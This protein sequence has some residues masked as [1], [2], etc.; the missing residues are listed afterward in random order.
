MK[1]LQEI[2]RVPPDVFRVSLALVNRAQ[3][4]SLIGVTVNE[5]SRTTGLSRLVVVESLNWL[6]KNPE[7]AP[8]LTLRKAKGHQRITLNKLY[9]DNTNVLLF[10]AADTDETRIARVEQAMLN[11]SRTQYSDR[12][13]LTEVTSPSEAQLIE[14]IERTM[15]R[16]LTLTDA[17]FLGKLLR[18]Y[19]VE[20][21]QNVFRQQRRAKEP[22]R[23]VYAILENGARGKSNPQA[24]AKEIRYPEL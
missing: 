9:V 4:E 15:G 5:L 8:F 10:T 21:V 17:F 20:R 13:G 3:K 16:A 24:S 1:W 11:A 6:K 22:L 23:A 12:S 7:G 18:G 19:G 14:E 2:T